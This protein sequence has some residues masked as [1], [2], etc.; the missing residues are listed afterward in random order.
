MFM[1]I[2]YT[3]GNTMTINRIH[4]DDMMTEVMRDLTVIKDNNEMVSKQVL[5]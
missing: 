3:Q 2:S 4:D 1:E 5:N